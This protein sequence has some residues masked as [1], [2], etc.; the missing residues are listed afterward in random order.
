MFVY[1]DKIPAHT[2][3]NVFLQ[4]CIQSLFHYFLSA[5][6]RRGDTTSRKI[7]ILRTVHSVCVLN[8]IMFPGF[9]NVGKGGGDSR[10]GLKN[11]IKKTAAQKTGIAK[12]TKESRL[13]KRQK[14]NTA[15]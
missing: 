3:D 6:C 5:V 10:G 15:K 13:K 9:G 11:L 8:I 7:Y 14:Y 2:T 12:L 4:R 1:F